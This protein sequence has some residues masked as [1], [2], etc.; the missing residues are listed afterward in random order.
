VAYNFVAKERAAVVIIN[1]RLGGDHQFPAPKQD[2][3]GHRFKNGEM[4]A[5]TTGWA[6]TKGMDR[7]Q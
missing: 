4:E 2:V 7:Y 5:V 1:R 6:I 3:C